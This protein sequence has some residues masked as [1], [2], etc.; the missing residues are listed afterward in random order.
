MDIQIRRVEPD[1]YHA[2]KRVY[3]Y[4]RVI[5]GTLQLPYPSIEQWRE[6]VTYKS[7]NNFTLVACA[8]GELVG[9]LGLFMDVMSHRRRHIAR[10]G[11]AVADPWQGKG[12]GTQLLGAAVDLAESWLNVLRLELEVYTDN[13]AAIGMYKKNGFSIEGTKK[14]DAFRNGEFVDTHIMARIKPSLL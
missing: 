14:A 6:R 8:D 5:A 9:N 7:N 13:H 1:D 4:P 12:I 11:M 2:L 3:E 10:L